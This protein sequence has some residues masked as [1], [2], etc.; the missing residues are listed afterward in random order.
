[1]TLMTIPCP[2]R[3]RL[4]IRAGAEGSADTAKGPVYKAR[5]HPPSC[6]DLRYGLT[7]AQP[8]EEIS[9]IRRQRVHF[10]NPC[11]LHCSFFEPLPSGP[12]WG[13]EGFRP[14]SQSRSLTR[15]PESHGSI[16]ARNSDQRAS[17]HRAIRLSD[18]GAAGSQ[19]SRF[20]R[21]HPAAPSLVPPR[22]SRRLTA[23]GSRRL[24]F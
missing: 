17:G 14:I 24:F 18:S 6:R 7:S 22:G 8:V 20:L 15:T 4:K 12:C 13:R 1:M 19:R 21:S 5:C 16:P 3:Y 11:Y 23:W 2:P 9:C 10:L